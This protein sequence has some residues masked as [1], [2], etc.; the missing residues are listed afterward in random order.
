MRRSSSVRRLPLCGYL[1]IITVSATDM[2]NDV[3]DEHGT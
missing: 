2:G 1:P 3:P